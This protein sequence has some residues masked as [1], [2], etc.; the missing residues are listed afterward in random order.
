MAV[1]EMCIRDRIYKEK[2]EIS[3]KEMVEKMGKRGYIIIDE[4]NQTNLQNPKKL[5]KFC[6]EIASGREGTVRFYRALE[7]NGIRQTCLLY[8]S[9]SDRNSVSELYRGY[10]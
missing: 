8:T 6:E 7:R 9:A 2:P 3:L 1:N 5:R 10:F 4:N